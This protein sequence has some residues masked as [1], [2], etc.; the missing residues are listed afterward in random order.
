[1]A[2]HWW[3][4]PIILATHEAE[5]RRITV[6]LE[7]ARANSSQYL[8]SKKTSQKRAGGVAQGVAL[9]SN[10]STGKKKKKDFVPGYWQEL[11]VEE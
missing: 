1:V 3:L 11:C 5:I 10:P 6:S 4:T 9:S 8:I 2:R 7:S